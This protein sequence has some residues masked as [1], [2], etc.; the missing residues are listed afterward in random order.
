MSIRCIASFPLTIDLGGGTIVV[1]HGL[2][3]VPKVALTLMVSVLAVPPNLRGGL[4]V[5]LP[6]HTP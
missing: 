2:R 3:A 4:K 6:F 5:T 1:R